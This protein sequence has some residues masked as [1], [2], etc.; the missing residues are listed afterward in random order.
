MS[1]GQCLS[2]T[3]GQ[4]ATGYLLFRVALNTELTNPKSITGLSYYKIPALL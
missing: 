2:F 1:T 3:L 4:I